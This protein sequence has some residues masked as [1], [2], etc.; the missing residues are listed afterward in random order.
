MHKGLYIG[1]NL[2]NC[3]NIHD[4]AHLANIIPAN[5]WALVIIA[6]HLARFLEGLGRGRENGDFAGIL[7]IHGS[8]GGL[9]NGL[10]ILAARANDQANDIGID[11]QF[12]MLGRVRRKLGARFGDNPGHFAKNMQPALPGLA[13]GRAHDVRGQTCNFDIHLHAGNAVGRA[14]NLE[15]HIAQGIFIAKNVGQD[16]KL[17]AFPD[18]PHGHAGNRRAHRHA[19]IHQ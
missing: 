6:D 19:R 8:A 11:H 3:A 2:D 18:Q 9:G 16:N 5:F 1:Q 4:L 17:V 7:D 10:D 13:H 12:R 14:G 15:V